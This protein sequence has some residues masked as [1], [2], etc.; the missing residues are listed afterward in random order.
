MRR[1]Q[2]SD[3]RRTVERINRLV[4]RLERRITLVMLATAP[5]R[6]QFDL[7]DIA[8]GTQTVAVA[9]AVPI[10]SDY[11]VQV[12][13][14]CGAAF[15]GLLTAG[16]Q[17]TSKTATGCTIIVANRGAGPAAAAAFSVLA[18]PLSGG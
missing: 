7:T 13:V 12:E 6:D 10:P 4:E 1:Q 16:V 18:F 2:E 5:R 17:A 8:V 9:W 3:R 11:H 14:V 15:V